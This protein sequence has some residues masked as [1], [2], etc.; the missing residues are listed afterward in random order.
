MLKPFLPIAN[1]Y[2]DHGDLVKYVDGFAPTLKLIEKINLEPQLR[3]TTKRAKVRLGPFQLDGKNV[4]IICS[5]Q[6]NRP[7]LMNLRHQKHNQQTKCLEQP[8]LMMAK[9]LYIWST[10]SPYAEL[11]RF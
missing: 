2:S 10:A 8:C 4:S 5:I 9:V 11:A 1:A 6:I 3:K 7:H